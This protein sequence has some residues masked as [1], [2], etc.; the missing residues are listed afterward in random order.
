MLDLDDFKAFN[1]A[2]GHPSGDELLRGV[3]REW[4]AA[5][6][7]SDLL[8][9]LGGDEFAVTLPDCSPELALAVIG[10][11]QE[12]T[13]AVIG[14]SAGIASSQTADTAEELLARADGAL[15]SAK[16]GRQRITTDRG[17]SRQGPQGPE[18]TRI[19]DTQ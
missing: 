7:G 15:Y 2:H 3:T 17:V 13:R 4:S 8:G 16:R 10:R 9:R 6:R 14:S 11:I 18:T 19:P 1:D 5:L 12:S